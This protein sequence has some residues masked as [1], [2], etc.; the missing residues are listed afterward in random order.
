[1]SLIDRIPGIKFLRRL[2]SLHVFRVRGSS[3]EP[4][5]RDGDLLLVFG[6]GTS[7]RPLQRGDVVVFRHPSVE[8]RMMLKRVAAIP[9]DRIVLNKGRISVDTGNDKP[10]TDDISEIEWNL[11]DDEWLLLGDNLQSSL[12]SRRLGPIQG[13]WIKGRVWLRL[14]PLHLP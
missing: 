10:E 5:L 11:G 4:A 12:D 3:M 14:W 9:G 8:K 6:R 13:S 2:G 1:M 7:D